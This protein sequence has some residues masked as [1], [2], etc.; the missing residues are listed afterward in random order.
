MFLLSSVVES[1]SDFEQEVNIKRYPKKI[2]IP[3]IKVYC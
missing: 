1:S 2:V 3:P